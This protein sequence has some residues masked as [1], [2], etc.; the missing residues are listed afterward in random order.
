MLQVLLDGT[1]LAVD[2]APATWG[3]LLERVDQVLQPR[4]RIVTD[5]HFDGLDE[6]AFREP[7]RLERALGPV[8]L[9]E[10][11]SGT[12]AALMDR[13]LVEAMSAIP[14]L[15]LA[16]VRV[17]ETFRRGEFQ[18]ANQ[19]LFEIAE[20]L[21]SLISIVGAAGLAFQVD[22]HQLPCGDQPAATAVTALGGHLETLVE[23]QQAEEWSA[24]A[25]V[26]QFQIEPSLRRLGPVL[27]SLRPA[28]LA[29]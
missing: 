2:P 25:H 3:T 22:L 11:T 16:T 6:P 15:S 20:G 1:P 23:A 8:A 27:E 21:A 14:P 10:V 7:A 4:G 18:G 26:L 9:V 17:A 29:S 28:E 5:A 19:G 13:C 12:P 24:V